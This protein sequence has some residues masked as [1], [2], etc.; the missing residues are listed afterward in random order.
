MVANKENWICMK[1]NIDIFL[2]NN[3]EDDVDFVQACQKVLK[4]ELL[5]ST[6]IYN[7]F[8]SNENYYIVGSE[9]QNVFSGFLC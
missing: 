8:Q 9:F 7:H 6:L 5:T 3:L 4:N 1:C 2:F